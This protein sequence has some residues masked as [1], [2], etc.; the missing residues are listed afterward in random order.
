MAERILKR[1]IITFL[2]LTIG[3]LLGILHCYMATAGASQ[4]YVADVERDPKVIA[5]MRYHG[6]LHCVELNGHYTFERNGQ[7]CQLYTQ[8]FEKHYGRTNHTR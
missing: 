8:A 3:W 7:T 1:I 2:I 4:D 6:I 5:A